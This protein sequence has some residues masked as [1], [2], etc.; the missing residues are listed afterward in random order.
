MSTKKSAAQLQREIDA[1]LKE[2]KTSRGRGGCFF[3]IPQTGQITEHPPRSN[4]YAY[5]IPAEKRKFIEDWI[6]AAEVT[7]SGL[8][9][10]SGFLRTLDVLERQ[11]GKG[12]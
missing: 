4:Y 6:E 10:P 7:S 1:V 11:C 9:Y 3:F 2:A 5:R 8:E 12:P